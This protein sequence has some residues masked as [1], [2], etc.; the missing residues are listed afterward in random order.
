MTWT[1]LA[2]AGMVVLVGS[3]VQGAVGF[4]LNLIGGPLLALLDPV[5]VPVPVLLIACVL[6]AALTLRE[7]RSVEWRGVGWAMVGRVPGN[8]LGLLALV[9]L[10]VAGFNLVIG[11]TVLVCVVLSVITWR[12]KVTAPNLVVAGTASGA[13]GTVSAIGGPPIALL[14][15]NQAGPT[16]RATL[17]AF[18]LIAAL[19]SVAT[20]AV[21]GQVRGEHLTAAAALTPFVAVGFLISGPARNLLSGARLRAAVLGIAAASAL[22]LIIRSL[23]A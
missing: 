23:L 1:V 7:L 8:L 9:L 17:N 11:A 19:S 18:F 13:F 16:V 3:I 5:F 12:P 2:V 21:A 6:A 14:Y 15:Q 22:G 10:P 20:L 4:G